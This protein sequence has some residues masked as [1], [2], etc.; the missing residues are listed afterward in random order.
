M[1]N[2]TFKL[3]SG[4]SSFKH[5][6]P[7][8]FTESTTIIGAAIIKSL[9]RRNQLDRLKL[10]GTT[11]FVAGFIDQKAASAGVGGTKFDTEQVEISLLHGEHATKTWPEAGD[12]ITLAGMTGDDAKL[13]GDWSIVSDNADYA[14]KTDGDKGYTLERYCDVDL[15][16]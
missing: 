10:E 2:P 5:F 14:R 13:N 4:Y 11:G 15:T 12:V 7:T 9:R 6:S 1:S 8:G 16:P 3:P